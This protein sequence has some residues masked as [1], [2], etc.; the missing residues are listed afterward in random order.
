MYM[1]FH[2]AVVINEQS[3]HGEQLLFYTSILFEMISYETLSR[4]ATLRNEIYRK[5]YL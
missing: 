4:V 5:V 2:Y 1:I 3:Y